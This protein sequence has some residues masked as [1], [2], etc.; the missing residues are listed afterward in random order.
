MRLEQEADHCYFLPQRNLPAP[1]FK[2]AALVL[3]MGAV[4]VW[5]FYKLGQGIREQK[6]VSLCYSLGETMAL[7]SFSPTSFGIGADRTPEQ[8]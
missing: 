5:G 1:G 6:Y 2:P 3:G 4:C 8:Q 7:S